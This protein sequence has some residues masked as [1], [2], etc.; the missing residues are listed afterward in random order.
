[1]GMDHVQEDLDRAERQ[2]HRVWL[3]FGLK[4]CLVT[5]VLLLALH[6]INVFPQHLLPAQEQQQRGAQIW[7]LC[8]ENVALQVGPY[9]NCAQAHEHAT[10]N[11]RLVALEHTIQATLWHANVLSWAWQSMGPRTSYVLLRTLDNVASSSVMLVLVVAAVVA[12]LVFSFRRGPLRAWADYH[13]V[14]DQLA[15]LSQQ[16]AHSD[17]TAHRV[18]MMST[19][20]RYR[21]KWDKDE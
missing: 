2:M 17:G 1:M 7:R 20:P 4:C 8:Q 5:A 6:I 10:M 21:L 14:H 11:V 12:W 9:T 13:M 18:H 3:W 19:T 15:Y 16:G